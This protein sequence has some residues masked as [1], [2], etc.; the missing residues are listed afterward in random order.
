MWLNELK[1]VHMEYIFNW[2]VHHVIIRA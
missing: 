1:S 2:Y